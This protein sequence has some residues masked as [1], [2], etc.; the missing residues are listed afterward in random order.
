MHFIVFVNRNE[1]IAMP[2]LIV[3]RVALLVPKFLYERIPASIIVAREKPWTTEL[4]AAVFNQEGVPGRNALFAG[5]YEIQIG[6]LINRRFIAVLLLNS[7]GFRLRGDSAE[8]K[9]ELPFLA[10]VDIV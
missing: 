9:M 2:F 8:F 10:G 6:I 1:S 4:P 7:V 3:L 5:F